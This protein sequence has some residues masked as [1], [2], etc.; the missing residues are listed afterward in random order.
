MENEAREHVSK[1]SFNN[2]L[3]AH[4]KDFA[5]EPMMGLAEA[6]P[7]LLEDYHG[8]EEEKGKGKGKAM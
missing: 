7:G 6:A 8:G 5:A 2:V 4:G 3:S 1:L